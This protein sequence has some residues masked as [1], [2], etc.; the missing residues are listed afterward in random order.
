MNNQQ[1][2]INDNTNPITFDNSPKYGFGYTLNF[3][4][5]DSELNFKILIDIVTSKKG[6]YRSS[7]AQWIHWLASYCNQFGMSEEKTLEYTL[8]HFSDHSKSLDPTKPIDIINQIETPIKNTFDM[9]PDQHGNWDDTNTPEFQYET[10]TLPDAIFEKIP[11]FLDVCNSF[12]DKRERDIIFLSTLTVLSSCFPNCFG[13]YDQREVKANLFT[14]ITAPPSSGKGVV[15]A[16]R[17]FGMAIQKMLDDKLK[18][19]MQE[20]YKLLEEYKKPEREDKSMEAP[21]QPGRKLLFIPTNNTSSK[22]ILSLQRNK[23]FGILMDTEADTLTYALKKEWGNFSD[24]LRKV[25]Q[26]E[27]VELER[28]LNDEFVRIDKPCLSI[29]L[30]GTP[31]QVDSMLTSIENGLL[32]RFI[33]YSYTSEIKWKNVFSN[34]V[35]PETYISA[36]AVDLLNFVEQIK[37]FEEDNEDRIEFKLTFLQQGKFHLWFEQ[38]QQQLNDLYGEDIIPSVR[39][40]GLIAFR[41]AMILTVVRQMDKFL[42]P[43]IIECSDD[44]FET[45]LSIVSCLLLHTIKIYNQLLNLDKTK[46]KKKPDALYFEKLP[47]SFNWSEAKSIAE[48]LNIKFKTAENYIKKFIDREILIREEHNK[49]LKV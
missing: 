36:R 10:P 34:E 44:D 2:T 26:H 12:S 31:R 21:V 13:L 15:S 19:A 20:Y 24:T 27:C 32:S 30:T 16:V 41:M 7:R 22:L 5:R 39:R 28:K 43:N 23:N 6:E 33:F 46:K 47:D 25:F 1:Q 35:V 18:D 14:F 29:L 11:K 38:Q 42:V 45:S 4:N 9:Y 3:N 17:D 49:Y 40:L 8:K 48:L 37:A